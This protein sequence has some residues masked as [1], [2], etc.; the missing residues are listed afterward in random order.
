MP[1]PDRGVKVDE[2]FDWVVGEVRAA[3]D[4]I[5]RLNDNFA[6]LGIE[7]V[8][9]ML[10]GEGCQEMGQLHDLVGSHDT[11]VLENVPEDVCKLVGEIV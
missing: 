9:S 2:M 8:L 10:N 6:V 1:L 3:P 5:L 11:T 7:G 4:T